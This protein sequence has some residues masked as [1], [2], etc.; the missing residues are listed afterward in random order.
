MT[1]MTFLE[2][3]SALSY[4]NQPQALPDIKYDT[5]TIIN[6]RVNVLSNYEDNGQVASEYLAV[7]QRGMLSCRRIKP[8]TPHRL[9]KVQVFVERTAAH[10]TVSVTLK[11][12]RFKCI[13]IIVL[14]TTGSLN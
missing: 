11:L 6:I 7:H 9:T 14:V 8:D 12:Q 10:L 5:V 4:T 3:L 1:V 13:N 2:Y